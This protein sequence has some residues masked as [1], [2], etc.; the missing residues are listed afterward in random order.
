MLTV[1]DTYKKK[2][3][4]DFQKESYLEAVDKLSAGKG[5]LFP[6]QLSVQTPGAL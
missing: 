5:I 3:N 4:M 2:K 1:W 6:V